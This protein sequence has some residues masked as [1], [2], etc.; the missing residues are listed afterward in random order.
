MILCLLATEY[1]EVFPSIN[2]H[3]I[4]IRFA[5][6]SHCFTIRYNINILP[7]VVAGVVIADVLISPIGEHGRLIV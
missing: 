3:K 6:N 7:G 2:H 1:S 5:L 4:H